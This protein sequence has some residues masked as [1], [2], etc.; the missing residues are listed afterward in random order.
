MKNKDKTDLQL[1]IPT[2]KK[3]TVIW[4]GILFSPPKATQMPG[5]WNWNSEAA[6][7]FRTLGFWNNTHG[8]L[9]SLIIKVTHTHSKQNME[10]MSPNQKNIKH[11]PI[12]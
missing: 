5:D 12:A 6:H 8:V 4:T 7:P 3:Y 1:N 11:T 2:F 9:F 10:N